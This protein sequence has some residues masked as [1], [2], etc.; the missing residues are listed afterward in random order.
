MQ[1]GLGRQLAE[2]RARGTDHGDASLDFRR[3]YTD[4]LQNWLR[5]EP[6]SI[7]GETLDPFSIVRA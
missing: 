2:N 3:V 1:L 7:L 5:I 4:V 6:H